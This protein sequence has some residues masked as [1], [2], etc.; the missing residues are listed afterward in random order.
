MHILSAAELN[1][2]L[3]G[4]LELIDSETAQAMKISVT[5]QTLDTYRR[6][7]ARWQQE[8]AEF[9]RAIGVRYIQVPAERGL[10]TILLGD[11]RRYGLLE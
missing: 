9:C 10:E 1:P 2:D 4:D 11:F 7:L 6:D 3:R 8:I 5:L